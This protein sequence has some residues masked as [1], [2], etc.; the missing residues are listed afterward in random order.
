M[1]LESSLRD[2]A[3]FLYTAPLMDVVLLLLVFFL[4]GSSFV[5]KSG[6]SVTVP[7]SEASLPPI[8]ASHVVTILPGASPELYFNEHKVTLGELGDYLDEAGPNIRHVIIRADQMAPHGLVMKVSNII[9]RHGLEIAY[10][11][12]QAPQFR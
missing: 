2:N 9:H 10:A 1:K 5:L 3:G 6:V 12:T 4:L 8:N 11:T 7:S